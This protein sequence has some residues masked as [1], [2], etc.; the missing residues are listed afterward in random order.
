MPNHFLHNLSASLQK[1]T[2]GKTT[3]AYAEIPAHFDRFTRSFADA[4]IMLGDCIALEVENSVSSALVLLYLLKVGYSFLLLPNLDQSGN[5]FSIP[6][7]CRYGIRAVDHTLKTTENE[8]WKPTIAASD[9]SK[10]HLYVRTSGSTGQPKL[11]V[12]AHSI[13]L[14]NALNCMQRLGINSDDR[15]TIPVPI[16]HLYGLGA[17]FLP[18]I[19]AGAAIN[20]QNKANLI[21]YLEREREFDPNI[22]FLIPSFCDLLVKGRRAN[23]NYRLTVVA[24]DR[25]KAETFSQYEARFGQIIP[26]YGSTEMGVIA[27][28]SPDDSSQNRATT[29]GQPLPGVQLRVEP[30]PESQLA[31]VGD[32][33]CQHQWRFVGYADQAGNLIEAMSEWFCTRDW[34]RIGDRGELEVLGRSDQSVNRDGLLVFFA[35][36][37]R[38][39]LQIKG[40]TEV[41]VI[42]A[43]E[44]VRGK[45]LVAYCVTTADCSLNEDAIRNACFQHLPQRAVPDRI[46]I[47]ESLPL[48]ANGKLDR[49]TLRDKDVY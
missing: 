3:C 16:Y 47:I 25:L 29:V 24:G 6:S 15:V 11:V 35:D 26:L 23:R 44:T 5:S 19:M 34:G 39:V 43:G 38:S 2:D 31:S 48:L 27:A 41:A 12:H 4:G 40:V 21:T 17:S 9:F 46:C 8:N 30:L 14:Q 18:S 49:Q 13:L 42:S 36:V 32:L 10:E 28:A 37:E 20:L 1:I 22:A 45:R 7:F 33:W